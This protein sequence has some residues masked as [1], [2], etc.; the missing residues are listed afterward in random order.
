MY[1]SIMLGTNIVHTS[2][3]KYAQE[4]RCS[5]RMPTKELIA[6]QLHGVKGKGLCTVSTTGGTIAR[7]W[8]SGDMVTLFFHCLHYL[9]H[10]NNMKCRGK[11]LTLL[12]GISGS[13][14][15]RPHP[16]NVLEWSLGMRLD[17]WHFVAFRARNCSISTLLCKARETRILA[18]DTITGQLLWIIED[19]QTV[20]ITV[21]HMTTSIP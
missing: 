7:E 17:F 13:L 16:K 9:L 14:V 20:T 15:P 18:V 12:S 2:S 1:Q 6:G 3:H 11:L 8:V 4:I 5:S 19:I 10:S 21:I